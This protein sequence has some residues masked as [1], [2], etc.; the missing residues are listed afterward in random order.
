MAHS[1]LGS[2]KAKA[3]PK[4]VSFMVLIQ[5][6]IR[7]SLSFDIWV[8][9]PP[10]RPNPQESYFVV[11]GQHSVTGCCWNLKSENKS[12][13]V[14]SVISCI[15][16]IIVCK[17]ISYL[18]NSNNL[19]KYRKW[20]QKGFLTKAYRLTRNSTLRASPVGG[21]SQQKLGGVW[22]ASQNLYHI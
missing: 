22:P 8:L 16:I 12:K 17:F 10:L 18:K 1:C 21:Y 15:L 7:A 4:L 11:L 2:N 20:E 14:S 9:P 13:A 19:E 6:F 5:L 3:A